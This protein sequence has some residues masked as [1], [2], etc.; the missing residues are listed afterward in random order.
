MT[1]YVIDALADLGLLAGHLDT[2]HRQPIEATGVF[3]MSKALLGLRHAWELHRILRR[4]PQADVL[5]PISQVRWGFIRDAVLVLVARAHRRRL[6]LHLHGGGL[7]GFYADSGCTMRA[8]IRA[9][10]RQAHSAWALTQ[11][12]ER[13]FDGLIDP[14]RVAHL[15]NVT[16]PPTDAPGNQAAHRQPPP[17]HWVANASRVAVDRTGATPS[18]TDGIQFRVLYL[19]NLLEDKGAFDLVRALRRI[20]A[21]AATWHVHLVGVGAPD[22][23]RSL[24]HEIAVVGEDGPAVE[25]SEGLYGDEKWAAYRAADAF[26]FPTRYPLEGQPLVLLEAMA[27]GL[28]ILTT[29]H[30]G[31]PDTIRHGVDGLLVPPGDIVA[32][33]DGVLRLWSDPTLR[34]SLG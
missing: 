18:A 19:G 17:S 31:I 9:V 29:R 25:I 26:V 22:V 21:D 15:E 27:V 28:A 7:D 11:T 20:G 3:G 13:M 24:R 5:L 12:L 23:V 10:F 6:R 8:M 16:S 1:T 33:A 30:G 4:T 32:I 14:S 2:R 34:S